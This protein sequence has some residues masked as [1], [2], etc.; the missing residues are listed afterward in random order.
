MRFMLVFI[1]NAGHLTGFPGGLFGMAYILLFKSLSI[2]S[3]HVSD[4]FGSAL[5]IFVVHLK[6]QL[7]A[8]QQ[9]REVSFS[10][11]PLAQLAR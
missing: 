2:H 7:L 4:F 8:E 5:A 3:H 9:S 11:T 6:N 10:C 1:I